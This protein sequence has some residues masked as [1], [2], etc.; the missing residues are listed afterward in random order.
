[1]KTKASLAAILL[2]GFL[3]GCA[4]NPP[5][6]PVKSVDLKR[7]SGKWYEIA[8][9]P[10]WFQKDCVG[11]VTAT[12]TPLPD[13]AVKVVNTC[14][15]ADGTVKS[16]TG[17]AVPVAGTE[18]ARLKVSFFGPFQ[19]DYWIIELDGKN[20]Q[21]AVVGHPSRKYLW[22]LSRQPQMDDRLYRKL[23]DLAV[24][25]GYVAAKIRKD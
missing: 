7:Y 15:K 22:I 25:Q 18:N 11:D 23:V 6:H 14:R 21:W 12:Y 3:S 9:Y 10:N 2:I 24:Q 17:R 13:G 4:T 20:Y 19:G 1:M 16:I 5:L 8:R